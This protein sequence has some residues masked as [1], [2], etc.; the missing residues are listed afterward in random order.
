MI[1]GKTSFPLRVP[2][3][4]T[5][6]S[7][8][9]FQALSYQDRNFIRESPDKT[10]AHLHAFLSYMTRVAEGRHSFQV[11]RIIVVYCRTQRNRVASPTLGR[12]YSP[13]CEAVAN[14]TN[15][16]KEEAASRADECAASIA[17]FCWLSD[18]T[19]QSA[20]YLMF[21]TLSKIF[22]HLQHMQLN[23]Q[24]RVGTGLATFFTPTRKKQ[25]TS[26]P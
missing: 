7:Y 8:P 12:Q 9:C 21:V 14:V 11:R 15:L 22:S 20:P 10:I 3:A 6:D 1:L 24:M 19:L 23:G 18:R 17:L 5:H 4:L 26:S 16:E 25:K 2:P 13:Q